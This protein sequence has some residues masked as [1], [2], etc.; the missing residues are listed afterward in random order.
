LPD[1]QKS[2]VSVGEDVQTVEEPPHREWKDRDTFRFHSEHSWSPHFKGVVGGKSRN[3]LTYWLRASIKQVNHL[4][5]D[6]ITLC[7]DPRSE[8]RVHAASTV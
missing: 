1:H 2:V 3:R 6:P 5:S 4:D 8:V 7:C